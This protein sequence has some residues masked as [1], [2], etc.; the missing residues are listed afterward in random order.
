MADATKVFCLFA[1]SFQYW[2]YLLSVVQTLFLS[3]QFLKCSN[4]VASAPKAPGLHEENGLQAWKNNLP[5]FNG[6]SSTLKVYC[7]PFWWWS[8]TTS[9]R[10]HSALFGSSIIIIWYM[11]DKCTR[12]KQSLVQ[13]TETSFEVNSKRVVT[14]RNPKGVP[15]QYSSCIVY[16]FVCMI[17]IYIHCVHLLQIL[18]LYA[19]WCIM[20]LRLALNFWEGDSEW[21][22]FT[23]FIVL[24]AWI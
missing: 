6:C 3:F 16:M 1:K 18:D 5:G 13:L 9:R 14:E 2:M 15:S 10:F 11:I 20:H 12:V 17:Y 4:L 8:F 7:P 21:F 24:S 19:L 22:L 23:E